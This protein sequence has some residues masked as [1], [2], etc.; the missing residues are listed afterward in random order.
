MKTHPINKKLL[1]LCVGLILTLFSGHAI[2]TIWGYSVYLLL[3]LGLI[4]FIYSI[5]VF[6]GNRINLHRGSLILFILMIICPAIVDFGAGIITYQMF[7]SFVLVAFFVTDKY[8]FDKIVPIYLSVMTWVTVIALICHYLLNNTGLLSLL[9]IMKNVNGIKFGVGIVF[10]YLVDAPNRNC[11]MFWEPGLFSTFL[12][13]ALVFEILFKKEKPSV[14]RIILF[15]IGIISSTSTAG[16]V[17]LVFCLLLPFVKKKRSRAAQFFSGFI[18]LSLILAVILIALNLDAIIQ[19]SSLADNEFV[20]KLLTENLADQS[21]LKAVTHNISL[22]LENPLL[23]AGMETITSQ[24]KYVADTSTSTYMLSLFGVLGAS[25]T[26]AWVYGIFRQ[27]NLN[28][29]TKIVLTVIF[30]SI[31]NKEPHIQIMFTW[32]L[33]FYLLKSSELVPS[34]SD[35]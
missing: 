20:T 28:I 26:I 10:N 32:C 18:S 25:Y 12:S 4:A 31:I 34:A 8:D 7:L 13:I 6:S 3:I 33:L 24:M 5:R 30:M 14:V 16:Y 17:L 29:L 35:S 15:S 23:G 21:R 27:K 22:F 2:Q 19:G 1:P 9:P 11:G